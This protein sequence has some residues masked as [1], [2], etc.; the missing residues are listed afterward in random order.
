MA[1]KPSEEIS[2]VIRGEPSEEISQVKRGEPA[3]EEVSAAGK[4]LLEARKTS[5]ND[6]KAE[7]ATSRPSTATV[8]LQEVKTNSL[9]DDSPSLLMVKVV[10]PE[11]KGDDGE[12]KRATRQAAR[13]ILIAFTKT[14]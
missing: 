12:S 10:T 14:R 1:Q 2:Q 8:R 5:E 11:S 4:S 13:L 7:S 3:E 6:E 9:L